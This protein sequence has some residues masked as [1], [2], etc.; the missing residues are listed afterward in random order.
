MLNCQ[1]EK[2]IR[3]LIEDNELLNL[4]LNQTLDIYFNKN[5]RHN[6]NNFQAINKILSSLLKSNQSLSLSSINLNHGD[7]IHR[8]KS[9]TINEIAAEQVIE[10]FDWVK[11]S[12]K[13]MN[14]E[15]DMIES[16]DNLEILIKK[17]KENRNTKFSRLYQPHGVDSELFLNVC[18][19]CKGNVKI[20]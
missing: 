18:V 10:Q 2:T 20:V 13:T 4:K 1:K 17:I 8:K 19:N 6:L 5:N 15:I 9:K 16:L 3:N 12:I 7:K 11:K 14:S